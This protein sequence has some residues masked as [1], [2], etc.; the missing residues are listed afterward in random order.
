MKPS[1]AENGLIFCKCI[2]TDESTSTTDTAF[3]RGFCISI[4]A[5]RINSSRAFAIRMVQ[6]EGGKIEGEC[7]KVEVYGRLTAEGRGG[8][9]TGK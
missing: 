8:T 5:A 3:L 7:G 6:I 9:R 1:S 4:M 2:G